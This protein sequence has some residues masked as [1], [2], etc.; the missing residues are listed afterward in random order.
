MVQSMS[1]CQ[2][3][4]STQLMV[5]PENSNERLVLKAYGMVVQQIAEGTLVYSPMALLTAKPFTA[6]CNDGII[7]SISRL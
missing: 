6:S 2:E 7:Q 5:Q 3:E 1:E 4:V